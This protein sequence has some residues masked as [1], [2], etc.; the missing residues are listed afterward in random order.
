[1]SAF[2]QHQEGSLTQEGMAL[3]LQA[4]GLPSGQT[5]DAL[6]LDQLHAATRVHSPVVAGR[7]TIY[8]YT[9]TDLW[10][11]RQRTSSRVLLYIPGNSSPLHEFVDIQHLRQWIV[12]QGKVGRDAAGV[13][14]ALCRR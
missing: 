14:H 10:C 13:G 11:F 9:S 2:L 1:M 7:L 8:R 5:W 6:T 3:A 4:A 12:A